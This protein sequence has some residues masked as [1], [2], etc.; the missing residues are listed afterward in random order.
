MGVLYYLLCNLLFPCILF[1]LG[2]G[3][4]KLA[5]V[6]VKE[7]VLS[8]LFAIVAV[9]LV[10]QSHSSDLVLPS[11]FVISHPL[12]CVT[13]LLSHKKMFTKTVAAFFALCTL[14]GILELW[15]CASVLKPI[16]G[17][18]WY[19]LTLH[20]SLIASLPYFWSPDAK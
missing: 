8:L 13:G 1:I 20:C 3:F 7:V 12:S 9:L 4:G 19:D 16:G 5:Q 11:L 10:N 2:V 6:T 17:H 15:G 18:L 14:V